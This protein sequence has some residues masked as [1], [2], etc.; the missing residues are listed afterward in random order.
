MRELRVRGKIKNVFRGFIRNIYGASKVKLALFTIFMSILDMVVTYSV[1]SANPKLFFEKELNKWFRSNVLNYGFPLAAVFFVLLELGITVAALLLRF[2]AAKILVFN[3]G[4][5]HLLCFNWYVHLFL[6]IS[7]RIIDFI[8]NVC[9][10]S[11]LGGTIIAFANDKEF[12]NSLF[13]VIDKVGG[14]FCKLTKR[15]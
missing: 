3:R 6:N 15:A 12:Y 14:K 4:L 11:L 2:R 7:T 13:R 1:Y 5:A 10:H 9:L 8:N